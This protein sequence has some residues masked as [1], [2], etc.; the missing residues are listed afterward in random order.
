MWEK[1]KI[2]CAKEENMFKQSFNLPGA[3]TEFVGEFK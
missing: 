3:G 1:V 2:C